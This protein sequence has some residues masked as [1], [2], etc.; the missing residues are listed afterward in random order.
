MSGTKSSFHG[1]LI[2]FS[3]SMKF[4]CDFAIHFSS[5]LFEPRHIVCF[6]K[7]IV[8]QLTPD[9]WQ[10]HMAYTGEEKC[11]LSW[12]LMWLF[13]PQAI[14]SFEVCFCGRLYFLY[15]V[16]LLLSTYAAH[17]ASYLWYR[18][19]SMCFIL[20]IAAHWASFFQHGFIGCNCLILQRKTR[21]IH[22]GQQ[23]HAAW[24]KSVK[25]FFVEISLRS[26]R[27]SN[28]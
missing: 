19:A 22:I 26:W 5:C 23:T 6:K 13:L 24:G 3:N 17:W 15:M 27:L 4:W 8:H 10:S 1:L 12:S 16:V 20:V 14:K 21:N 9:T 18:W 11:G 25:Y 7:H 28:I 2:Y